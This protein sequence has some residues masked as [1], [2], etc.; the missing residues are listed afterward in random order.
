MNEADDINETNGSDDMGGSNGPNDSK[1]PK[2][3]NGSNDQGKMNEGNRQRKGE[4]REGELS[5]EEIDKALSDF[6]S[7]FAS[8]SAHDG[9]SGQDLGDDWGQDLGDGLDQDLD[10]LEDFD[11]QLQGILGNK[12]KVALLITQLRSARF[13]A[14]LCKLS[15]ISALCLDSPQ[16]ACAIL[17]DLDGDRPEQAAKQ[18]TSMV[19][20]FGLVLAVNRADKVDMHLWTGG[21]EGDSFA[22]PLVLSSTALFVEDLLT[23]SL[24]LKDLQ[25]QGA[26]L[27]DSGKMSQVEA[28]EV[29]GEFLK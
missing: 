25:E 12:A 3:L 20:G 29:I 19:N 9:S 18:L 15:Q 16:G 4:E 26:D 2:G 10:Q 23:G 28:Y 21:Q 1:G 27:I 8:F 11:E 6:E 17:T 5:D 13:L 24:S 7:E 22:P 14:A